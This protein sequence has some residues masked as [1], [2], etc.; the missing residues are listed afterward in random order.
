MSDKHALFTGANAGTVTLEDGTEVDLT[1]PWLYF[2]TYEEV[3]AV[4]A[5]IESAHHNKKD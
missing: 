3:A 5:A 2:D 1:E 4:A